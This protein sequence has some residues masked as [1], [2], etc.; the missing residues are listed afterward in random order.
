MLYSDKID[1]NYENGKE[2]SLEFVWDNEE[3]SRG[4]YMMEVYEKTPTGIVIIGKV[5]KTLE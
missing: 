2:Q 4:D 1:F 3:S 5:T